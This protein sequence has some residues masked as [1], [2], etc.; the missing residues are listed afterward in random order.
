MRPEANGES[1]AIYTLSE[2]I[3][4]LQDLHSSLLGCAASLKLHLIVFADLMGTLLLTTIKL[5][6]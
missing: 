3:L 6:S 2:F 4:A 5:E 1:N